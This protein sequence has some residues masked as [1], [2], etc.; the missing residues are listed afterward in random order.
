MQKH[1]V[2][3]DPAVKTAELDCLNNIVKMAERKCTY[4]LPAMMGLASLA[5]ESLDEIQGVVVFGSAASVHDNLSWQKPFEAWLGKILERKIPTFAI[6]Y[7]HQMIAHMFGGR[8]RYIEESRQK[9]SGFR[10]IK[11]SEPSIFEKLEGELL[12]SHNELVS[13]VPKDFK[14]IA[15]SDKFAADALQHKNLPIFSFQ[16]HPEAIGEFVRTRNIGHVPL[17]RLQFGHSLVQNFLNFAAKN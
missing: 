6:C 1:F 9:Q 8:V 3:I 17:E 7:G 16:P 10:S 5:T 12:V 13:E 11:F 15:R 4:H 14:E 2:V